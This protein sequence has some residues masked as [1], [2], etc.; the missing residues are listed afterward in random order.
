MTPLPRA[1]SA[2][3]QE[4]SDSDRGRVVARVANLGCRLQQRVDEVRPAM[5][6]C[7]SRACL[8]LDI[9]RS[10]DRPVGVEQSSIADD[11]T[12]MGVHFEPKYGDG[13]IRRNDGYVVEAVRRSFRLAPRCW[14]QH[15]ARESRSRQGSAALIEAGG[16]TEQETAKSRRH[17]LL[18]RY[19][20]VKGDR[21]LIADR[22]LSPRQHLSARGLKSTRKG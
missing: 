11:G 3:A 13:L 17:R 16:G 19:L 20:L 1:R 10:G 18:V 21:A 6:Y 22:H 9:R 12:R 5:C 4:V 8:R 2:P 14:T 7:K 15:K